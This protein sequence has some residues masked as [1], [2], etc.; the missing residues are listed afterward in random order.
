MRLLVPLVLA[1]SLSSLACDDSTGPSDLATL[2]LRLT[3]SPFSDADAV[4]VTFSEVAVHRADEAWTTVPFAGGASF[5]TCDLK[6]LQ[7]AQDVLGVGALSPGHY[8]Q[9]RL[10]VASAYLYFDNQSAG[11]ACAATIPS[12]AGRNA[13]L[14]V[15][16]GEVKLNRQFELT[17]NDA[18]TIVLDFD[19]DKSIKETGNGR[20]LM[21][22]VIA[23]VS[24]E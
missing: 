9:I 7:G 16:S 3:D 18:M 2:N 10:V 6:K 13:P 19:G 20:Y 14:E 1:V 22:P 17:A 8:T 21:T 23:I 15:P 12:P 4:L 5:R 11:P 24:V